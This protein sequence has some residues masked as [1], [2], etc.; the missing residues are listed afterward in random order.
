M[1]E[2]VRCISHHAIPLFR[3]VRKIRQR[4]FYNTALS[5]AS[6]FN[7]L[8]AGGGCGPVSSEQGQVSLAQTG[9][10]NPLISKRFLARFLSSEQ[11]TSLAEMGEQTAEGAT[12]VK[13]TRVG[14]L[15]FLLS[16][17]YRPL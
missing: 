15:I 7:S 6:N 12:D 16:H 3:K 10:P 8:A 1:N 2:V 11:A 5:P 9:A 4:I 14:F 13:R 17:F